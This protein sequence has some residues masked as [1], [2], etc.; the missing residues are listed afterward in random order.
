MNIKI[1]YYGILSIEK[2]CDKK[3]IRNA[4]F[5]LSKEHH[6]DKG[7]DVESFNMIKEAYDVLSSAN[8]VEY[9]SKSKFGA[10]YDDYFSLFELNIDDYDKSNLDKS[11][12]KIIKFM[13]NDIEVRIDKD[14]DDFITY[15]RFVKC[16][17]C[18]GKGY[19]ENSKIEIKDKYGKIHIYDAMDGC[20]FCEGTGEYND[21][22]CG[23]CGGG[24]K[25]GL[26]KCNK[27]K[28]DK[29]ILGIQKLKYKSKGENEIISF[30]GSYAITG[31]VG[32]LHIII[33]DEDK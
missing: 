26:H 16:K 19:D 21:T 6:P 27:C 23:F 30:M 9:D 32:N 25:V 7:G 20:D 15:E 4:Y 5:K 2:D 12:D 10:N 1:D 22:T 3:D 24:G 33:E 14:F 11:R 31:Q 29:R 18:D 13:M 28:G 17:S 8:R